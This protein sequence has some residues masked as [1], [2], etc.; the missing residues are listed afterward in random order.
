[1][2]TTHNPILVYASGMADWFILEPH[3]LG[4]GQPEGDSEEWQEILA[5]MANRTHKS[6][7]R[8]A[9]IFEGGDAYLHSPRNSD[10]PYSYTIFAD[11]LD[12]WIDQ[13]YKIL[14]AYK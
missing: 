14:D 10:D 11:K 8:V 4:Q 13:A 2:H 6:F 3:S 9:V 5:A 7:K 12:Q 1:M